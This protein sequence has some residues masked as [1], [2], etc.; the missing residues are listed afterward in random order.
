MIS[1][2]VY[3]IQ[4]RNYYRRSSVMNELI[5]NLGTC[6]KETYC[7]EGCCSDGCNTGECSSSC[8][9]DGCCSESVNCCAD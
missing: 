4:S 1:F 5:D 2:Q 7:A 6:C 9:N 3:K 8:C